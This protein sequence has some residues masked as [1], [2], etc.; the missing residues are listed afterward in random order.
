MQNLPQFKINTNKCTLPLVDRKNVVSAAQARNSNRITL[1]SK[2]F[3]NPSK[4]HFE[5]VQKPMVGDEELLDIEEEMD[6]DP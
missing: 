5:P 2:H 3:K 4:A 1:A 6:S